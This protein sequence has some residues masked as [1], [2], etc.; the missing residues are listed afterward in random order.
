MKTTAHKIWIVGLALMAATIVTRINVATTSSLDRNV[1]WITGSSP[2]ESGQY[3]LFTYPD[4]DYLK[5]KGVNGKRFTKR[6]GCLSGDILVEK[7][8]RFYCNGEFIAL[9]LTHDRNDLAMPEFTHNGAI[10]Q[11]K[12]FMVGDSPFSGDSRYLGFVDIDHVTRVV[13]LW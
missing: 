8:R 4:N 13:P 3:G 11:G 1:F 6:V 9:K 12:A 2:S 10:P 7:D 5:T